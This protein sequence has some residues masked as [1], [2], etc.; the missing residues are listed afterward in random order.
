MYLIL[1]TCPIDQAQILAEQLVQHRHAACVNLLPHI[2]SIYRW[3]GEICQDKETLMFIKTAQHQV[4]QCVAYL[5]EI[6]PYDVPEIITF[7]VDTQTS[8]S[9]YVQWVSSM[10]TT[11]NN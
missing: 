7:P 3:Q 6:H 8:L 10:T 11:H 2:H 9:A 5:K 4:E 1:S